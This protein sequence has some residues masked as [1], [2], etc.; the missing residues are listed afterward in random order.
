MAGI[1]IK[2]EGTCQHPKV[3][4][5]TIEEAVFGTPRSIRCEDCHEWLYSHAGEDDLITVY[6]GEPW[7]AEREPWAEALATTVPDILSTPS[8]FLSDRG[9]E[10]D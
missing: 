10:D 8:P 7:S 6:V 4:D 2:R 9:T 1:D 3:L 5:G